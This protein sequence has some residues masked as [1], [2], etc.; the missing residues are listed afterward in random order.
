M[1]YAGIY[2]L[3]QLVRSNLLVVLHACADINQLDHRTQLLLFLKLSDFELNKLWNL[4]IDV[5]FEDF[6]FKVTLIKIYDVFKA[7]LF[8]FFKFL[9]LHILFFAKDLSFEEWTLRFIFLW[10]LFFLFFAA[11]ELINFLVQRDNFSFLFL[12]LKFWCF[13]KFLKSFKKHIIGILYLFFRKNDDRFLNIIKNV[14]ELRLF[15]LS[16]L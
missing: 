3:K 6:A 1:R 4:V 11:N 7:K 8:D 16:Y 12:Y 13:N 5:C 2:H 14:L 9:S 10:G 15:I